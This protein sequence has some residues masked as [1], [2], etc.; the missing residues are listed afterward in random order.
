MD[1]LAVRRRTQLHP[2]G[3]LAERHR[4]QSRHENVRR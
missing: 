4:S 2:A 3:V 1:L